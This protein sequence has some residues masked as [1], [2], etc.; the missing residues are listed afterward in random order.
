MAGMGAARHQIIAR[1]FRGGTG[2][3][4]GFHIKEAIL[5]EITTNAAGDLRAQFQLGSHLW[6]TQVDK[7]ITKTGFF[8]DVGVLIQ[9][10]RRRFCLIEHFQLIAQHFNGTGRH[11]RIDR[12]GRASAHL[13]ANPHYVLATHTIS[14]SEGFLTIRVKHHLSQALT[15]ANIK[16]NHTTV[17]ATAMNPAAKSDFLIRQ[18]FIQ[19]AA[20]VGTHHGVVLPVIGKM[21]VSERTGLCR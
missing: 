4:G 3:N 5:I 10:K 19:L 9:R 1:T 6:A 16:K 21:E 20:I 14:Q 2:E 15:I 13:A 11:V 18:R 8:A 7:T 12:T 17:V